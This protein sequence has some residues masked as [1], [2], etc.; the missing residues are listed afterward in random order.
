MASRENAR[1]NTPRSSTA[2]IRSKSP[3]SSA[4]AATCDVQTSTS[5]A[6]GCFRRSASRSGPAT[7]IEPPPMNLK[8]RIVRT[9]AGGFRR[10]HLRQNSRSTPPSQRSI[11][12]SHSVCICHPLRRKQAVPRNPRRA[13][14]PRPGTA[15]PPGVPC[16]Y[17]LEYTSF[18][19]SRK[20]AK[21]KRFSAPSPRFPHGPA[22]KSRT[23]L[24]RRSDAG[25]PD[26]RGLR[27]YFI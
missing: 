27:S 9:V 16:A 12:S 21:N 19:I 23:A 6:S 2:S 13:R 3:S 8:I 11:R 14:A 5:R 7:V 10:R 20:N 15:P 25:G 4:C 24:P 1:R 18:I 26:M 17:R 22:R